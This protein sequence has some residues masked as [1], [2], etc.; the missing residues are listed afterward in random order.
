MT[1]TNTATAP[2]VSTAPP[3]RRS[4]RPGEWATVAYAGA[5]LVIGLPGVSGTYWSPKAAIVLVARHGSKARTMAIP[6]GP[7]LAFG[8]IVAFFFGHEILDAYLG[9][10]F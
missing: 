10:F 1:A 8:A 6:F 3:D 5:L 7:F 9:A 2:P 4:L